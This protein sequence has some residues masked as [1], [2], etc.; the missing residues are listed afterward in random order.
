VEEVVPAPRVTSNSP[1]HLIFVLDDSGSMSGTAANNLNEGLDTMIEEMKLMSQG[2]KPYF[3]LSV[4]VFGTN[5]Q[6]VSEAESEQKVDKTKVTSFSGNSG[7]TNL[8]EALGEA[9]RILKRHPGNATD[10]DPY[11]FLLTDGQADDESTAVSAAKTLLGTQVAAGKPRLIAIGL[12]D[13]V[14]M[15]FL[16]KIASNPELAKHLHKP[17]ELVKFFPAI[18]TVVSSAGGAQA[19]DQAIVDI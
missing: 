3:K 10:F 8:T 15:S 14:N 18:G 9:T 12:G 6:V 13:N 7:G 17:S 19:V 5:A 1:W 2:T 11:V 16:Q 4:I